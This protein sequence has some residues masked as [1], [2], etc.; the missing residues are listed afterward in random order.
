MCMADTSTMPSATSGLV[1]RVLHVLGDPHELAALAV[2][3]VR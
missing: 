3:K 1:D 2:V